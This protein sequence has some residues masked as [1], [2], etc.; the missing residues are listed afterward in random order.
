MLEEEEYVA[1]YRMGFLSRQVSIVGRQEVLSGK[2]KFGIFGDGKEL[3]QLALAHAFK[4]GDWRS[5][6][7][8]DQTWV[9]ALGM[10]SLETYFA[11]LY[12]DAD[13]QRESQTG[14]RV[15]NSHFATRI[16]NEEGA[17]LDQTKRFNSSSDVSPTASQM[18]RSVG[19][20]YASVLYRK[21]GTAFPGSELFS[22][23]GDEVSWVSIGNAS[24][25]E[26]HFWESVNAIGVLQAPAVVVV[27]D[28]GFGISV[29]NQ[30]QMVKENISAILEGF[31][32]VACPAD[33]CE[34]GFDLYTVPAWDYPEL[35]SVFAK[36]GD[37]ARKDHIP[38]LIHVTDC[39]QPLGHST[40]GS[41][42]RYKTRERLDW[43]TENDCLTRYRAWLIE[44][45]YANDTELTALEL[46]ASAEV[47]AARQ[48]A[49]EAFRSPLL[50]ERDGAVT[51]LKSIVPSLAQDLAQLENP[52]RRDTAAAVHRALVMTRGTAPLSA[53]DASQGTA[54][55]SYLHSLRSE[56]AERY[57]S[58]LYSAS[59]NAVAHFAGVPPRYAKEAPSVSGF[60]L[61]N[62]AF[63]AAFAR[64]GRVVAFGED[65]GYLGDV[66][67]GFRGLQEK[68]G[69][70][71]ISDTGIREATIIG[72]GIGLALR[73]FRPIAEIQYLDYLLYGLQLL[74]DDLATLHWRTAGG[75]KAPL[76]V[77]TRGHRL[78]GVWHSGSPMA[79]ILNLTRGL[80]VLVPRDFTQAAAFYNTL[81]AS[82]EPGIVVEVLNA[83]RR[84]ELMP[85]NLGDIRLP[86]GRCETL[87]SGKDLTVLSYGAT[88]RLVLE[89]AE[90]LAQLGAEL[91]VIDV[92]SLLPFDTKHDI[93]ASIQKTSRV[94][95]WMKMFPAAPPPT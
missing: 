58:H 86:L 47:E 14:G 32:R 88:L 89:A 10:I 61:I 79:G 95:L 52:L 7:Y 67:Q 12:A 5:G 20:A 75:Q 15:M 71:R 55:S 80:N 66:N 28:D 60:E 31:R 19:L 51:L 25:A 40:S 8:R 6:Y 87:R 37:A 83:Y 70:Y 69:P 93:L 38:A 16:L 48:R 84:K 36:A 35:I 18:P 49:Y 34:R 45:G 3:P 30:F 77:R 72:Q 43:E 17:W 74:S 63:D 29:P 24:T 56:N 78:E 4:K 44:K 11:Q 64:D 39:T 73:G 68:Y 53:L 22:H 26:G 13:V 1:D 94:L 76:I 62:A 81:L 90:R 54:L 46:E 85:E 33:H 91:E 41:H 92:Q 27:Y 65:L 21:L 82:D 2:A 9:F 23:N 57:G 50:A 59:E 42:E